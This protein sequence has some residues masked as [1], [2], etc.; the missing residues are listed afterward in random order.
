MNFFC[1]NILSWLCPSRYAG[2]EEESA[3]LLRSSQNFPPGPGSVIPRPSAPIDIPQP[4]PSASITSSLQVNSGPGGFMDFPDQRELIGRIKAPPEILEKEMTI[5]RR[6][7]FDAVRQLFQCFPSYDGDNLKLRFTQKDS[8]V[9][10]SAGEETQKL[11][12]GYEDPAA[13]QAAQLLRK[14]EEPS[15]DIFEDRHAL[16]Q[17]SLKTRA[18]DYLGRMKID[19]ADP[20]YKFLMADAPYLTK[21]SFKAD[22]NDILGRLPQ[23]FEEY[24]EFLREAASHSR[25]D[26]AGPQTAAVP[27]YS[28]RREENAFMVTDGS[29]L[30]LALQA[31][32]PH[33]VVH[34]SKLSAQ[35]NNTE[36][37]G[38]FNRFPSGKRPDTITLSRDVEENYNVA[39]A[40]LDGLVVIPADDPAS[41]AIDRYL[42]LSRD[43]LYG[44]GKGK[45]VYTS[46]PEDSEGLCA[47]LQQRMQAHAEAVQEVALERDG[48]V[49]S[50]KLHERREDPPFPR[51]SRQNASLSPFSRG[52]HLGRGG[53][54]ARGK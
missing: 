8:D 13:D 53:S 26:D 6:N 25:N 18:G 38:L 51:R 5:N 24:R 43:Q 46:N 37:R 41:G 32:Q 52:S 34:E 54:W 27:T 22:E 11:S 19:P 14:F 30:E 47:A 50:V 31:S 2:T 48:Q 1:S 28:L 21:M 33:V 36:I 3:S 39:G 7:S 49:I 10:I 44:K 16:L 23:H 20:N 12:L 40:G 45:D 35:E 4:A 9:E 17:F 42:S 15:T 29:G